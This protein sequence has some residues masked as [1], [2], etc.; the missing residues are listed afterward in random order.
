MDVVSDSETSLAG[1]CSR[2][3]DGG[4]EDTGIVSITSEASLLVLGCATYGINPRSWMQPRYTET[5][6][7]M[8]CPKK[9]PPEKLSF[10]KL[11]SEHITGQLALTRLCRIHNYQDQ[12]RVH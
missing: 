1:E 11:S 10:E 2:C 4:N 5:S 9:L 3:K 12:I 7:T 8:L 6:R